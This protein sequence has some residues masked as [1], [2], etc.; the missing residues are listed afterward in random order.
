MSVESINSGLRVQ[1][2]LLL[3]VSEDR[4]EAPGLV[5]EFVAMSPGDGRQLGVFN[6][7]TGRVLLEPVGEFVP[8]A[9]DLL[10]YAGTYW[11]EEA[12]ATYVVE[13]EGE[14]LVIKSRY[15]S[16]VELT[17]AYLDAFAS[18]G[19][20]AIFRRNGSNQVNGMSLSLGRVWDLRFQ[21]LP[22]DV[23]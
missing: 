22:K 14:Q 15:S 7:P 21:K 9:A 20:T 12:E 10:E 3:P 2:T 8:T 16:R 6:T 1:G 13:V 18:Q 4:F 19:R 23:E 17:P 5:L 11:S